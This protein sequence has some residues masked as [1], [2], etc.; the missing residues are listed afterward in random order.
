MLF[1]ILLAVLIVSASRTYGQPS[2]PLEGVNEREYYESCLDLKELLIKS[3]GEDNL[4]CVPPK[5]S[6]NVSSNSSDQTAINQTTKLNNSTTQMENTTAVKG[7]TKENTSE[8]K[9]NDPKWKAKKATLDAFCTTKMRNRNSDA[10][11]GWAPSPGWE[12]VGLCPI[13][14]WRHA[15]FNGAPG[16][17]LPSQ[18]AA[19]QEPL[20][21][22]TLNIYCTKADSMANYLCLGWIPSPGWLNLEPCAE[23]S[24][25]KIN[26]EKI[27]N[28]RSLLIIGQDV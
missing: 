22:S 11:R 14:T 21:Q 16:G 12:K 24:S 2:G 1:S 13:G 10:C 27:F 8:P 6:G 25:Q 17:C 3:A 7:T 23:G 26:A 28:W 20:S 15:L 18:K 5:S 9:V 19:E 4:V